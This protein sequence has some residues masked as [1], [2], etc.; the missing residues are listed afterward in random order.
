MSLTGMTQGVDYTGNC[1]PGGYSPQKDSW[2]L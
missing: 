2:T 1:L